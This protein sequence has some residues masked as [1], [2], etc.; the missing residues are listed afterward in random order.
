MTNMSSEVYPWDN[1]R[2]EANGVIEVMGSG[3]SKL[4]QEA[5]EGHLD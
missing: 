1:H 5:N 3:R 2:V 4:G